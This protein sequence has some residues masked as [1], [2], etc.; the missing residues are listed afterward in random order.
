MDNGQ[1][2]NLM[3]QTREDVGCMKESIDNLVKSVDAL[4]AR[5]KALEDKPSQRWDTCITAAISSVIGGIVGFVISLFMK[6]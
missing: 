5:V 1:I 4:T 6:K 2:F 3:V